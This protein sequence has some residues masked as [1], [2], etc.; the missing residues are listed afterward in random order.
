MEREMSM[1]D[2]W[3]EF[4]DKVVPR[5]AFS[6]Q[7][8]EMKRAFYAGARVLLSGLVRALDT[9]HEPTAGDLRMVD[10]LDRELNEFFER[11]ARGQE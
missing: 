4:A 5:A 7:R 1:A 3:R 6:I 10:R 2:E 8:R 11:L 9:D